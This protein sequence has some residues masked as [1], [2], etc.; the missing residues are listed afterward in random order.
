MNEMAWIRDCQSRLRS[1]LA[2]NKPIGSFIST[3][4]K[5]Y[6]TLFPK[7]TME[8]FFW[9]IQ[10]KAAVDSKDTALLTN[11]MQNTRV[12]NTITLNLILDHYRN[13]HEMHTAESILD[14]AIKE[15]KIFLNRSSFVTVISGW[16]DTGNVERMMHWYERLKEYRI[17]ENMANDLQPNT[18]LLIKM[19]DVLTFTNNFE[20]A[21]KLLEGVNVELEW[22]VWRALFKGMIKRGH[23]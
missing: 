13:N 22:P 15:H 11:V 5:E 23:M 18:P 7:P 12:M 6:T 8:A 9:N 10:I 4:H 14:K 1:L 19:I 20:L 3:I 2:A 21:D 16:A 17:M